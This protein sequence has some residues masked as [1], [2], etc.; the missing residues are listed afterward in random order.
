MARKNRNAQRGSQR[1]KFPVSKGTPFV[2]STDEF[3]EDATI[4]RY[5]GEQDG[6]MLLCRHPEG[7][8]LWCHLSYLSR[9]V[10]RVAA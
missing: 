2:F 9:S 10:R 6:D 8:D 4:V 3:G 7:F 5:L 1:R